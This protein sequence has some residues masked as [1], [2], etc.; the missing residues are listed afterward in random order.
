MLAY[1]TLVAMHVVILIHRYHSQASLLTLLKKT[2]LMVTTSSIF[3]LA[4]EIANK[5][6]RLLKGVA[7]EMQVSKFVLAG[8]IGCTSEV[9]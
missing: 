5:F 9:S 2:A 8:N 7:V 6:A 1:L 3:I 4:L